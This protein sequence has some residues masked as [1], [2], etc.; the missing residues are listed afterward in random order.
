MLRRFSVALVTLICLALGPAMAQPKSVTLWHVFNLETDMIHGG[1]KSFNETQSAYRIDARLVPANQLVAELIKAIATGSVPDLVTL[2]NPAVPSFSAPGSLLDL[3]DRVGRSK[4]I[5]PDVYFK[6]PW[7]SGLWKGRIFAVPRDA[8]T[9]ALCY[10]ADMFRAKGL[11][12]ASPPKTWSELVTDAAKLTDPA[13]H[14]FG[15]GFSAMQAEEGVFQWLPFL[16]QAGGSIDHLNAPEAAE[17][18]QILVDFVKSGSASLDVLNQRQYEVT[19]T[20]M[21]GNAAMV[22]CGPWELPRLKNEA[23]FDWR[24]ALLPV[25]DGKNIHASSLGGYDWVIPKDAQDPDGAFAF[26]EYMAQPKI[27]SEGWNTGRLPPRTDI[28]IDNP[29]WPQAYA[30]YHEQLQTARPRGP[31]PQWPDIS[32]PMQTAIQEAITGR[33]T[34]SDALADAAKKIQPILAKTPL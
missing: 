26:I 1:I 18:L 11:D 5:K 10:N 16:Y 9:L 30:I 7:A 17:S 2:D 29:Q 21:A 14:V 23:K 25:K 22:M 28:V 3:T 12:P 4:L 27:V 33:Q 32:R 6:G 13:K 20:F 24:L 8:N 15:F 31:H 34:A 19:N